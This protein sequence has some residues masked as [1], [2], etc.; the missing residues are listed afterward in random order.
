MKNVKHAVTEL[1]ELELDQV[2]GGLPNP[3]VFISGNKNLQ[4][5]ATANS[6]PGT[7][8]LAPSAALEGLFKAVAAKYE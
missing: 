2:S 3:V 8:S 7:A 4:G 1:S 6:S 5:I